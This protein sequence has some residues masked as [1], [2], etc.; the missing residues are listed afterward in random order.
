MKAQLVFAPPLQH[1]KYGELGENITPPLGILYLA[2]YLRRQ[3]PEI[4]LNIIDG[5]KIGYQ[6]TLGQIKSY[7]PDVL[8]VSFYTPVALSAFQL[9]N[10]V[11]D[12][13]PGTLIVA[14]GPHATAL[15][16]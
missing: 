16:K 15:P 12:Y 1:P 13:L 8:G 5:P 11:K 7:R 2:G 4:E 14:G 3:L 6:N 10:D 9:I